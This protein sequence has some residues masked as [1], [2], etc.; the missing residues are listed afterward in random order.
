MNTEHLQPAS[1]GF[2]GDQEPFGLSTKAPRCH[3]GAHGSLSQYRMGRPDDKRRFWGTHGYMSFGFSGHDPLPPRRM[4]KVWRLVIATGPFCPACTEKCTLEPE[5][6]PRPDSR[7]SRDRAPRGFHPVPFSWSLA[8]NFTAA[9]PTNWRTPSWSSQSRPWARLEG[10]G[11]YRREYRATVL[12]AP[13]MGRSLPRCV[14]RRSHFGS[15]PGPERARGARPQ[16]DVRH[17]HVTEFELLAKRR[18]VAPRVRNLN[19]VSVR[20]R[21]G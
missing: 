20:T 13:K 15:S 5:E 2:P 7:F 8:R 6:R 1:V 11:V 21:L 18:L 17:P 16:R 9:I 12:V 3:F 14:V 19:R 10:S 4:Q